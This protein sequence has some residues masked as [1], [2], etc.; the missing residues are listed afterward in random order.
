MP[1]SYFLKIFT[2][3]FIFL[4][5]MAILMTWKNR[6]KGMP[7]IGHSKINTFRDYLSYV[8]E[9]TLSGSRINY[10]VIPPWCAM[11]MKLFFSKYDMYWLNR[12]YLLKLWQNGQ[13]G[14]IKFAKYV[15]QIDFENSHVKIFAD[16][17]I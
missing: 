3:S 4:H 2:E 17:R 16:M 13:Y 12:K 8:V 9:H 7:I 14:Y 10:E 15:L 11:G 5:R 6:K 1:I